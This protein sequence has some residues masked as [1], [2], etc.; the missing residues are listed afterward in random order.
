MNLLDKVYLPQ[1]EKDKIRNSENY[2]LLKDNNLDPTVLEGYESNYKD[3]NIQIKDFDTFINEGGTK[4]DWIAQHVTP[5]NKKAFFGTIGDFIVETGKDTLLSLGVAGINGADVAVNMMPLV[6]KVLDNSPL[7]TA[8][9]KGFM[10][11]ET[12]ADVYNAAK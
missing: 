1:L 11:A 12:E 2:K 7:A 9:P 4:E 10:N 8:L 5:E 3:A 6:A